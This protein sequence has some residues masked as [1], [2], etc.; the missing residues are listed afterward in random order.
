MHPRRVVFSQTPG[1]A[2]PGQDDVDIYT[3]VPGCKRLAIPKKTTDRLQP[4]DVF[5]SL[6]MKSIIL[7]A[8][9]RVILD[10]LPITKRTRDNIIRLVSLM[11]NQMSAKFFNGLIR[12]A[13]FASGYVDKHPGVFKTVD[14]VCFDK[15]TV[16]CQT[17]NCDQSPFIRCS[18][19]DKSLC[20]NHFFVEYDCM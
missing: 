11:H 2:W 10:Q 13:C 16:S 3:K 18:W 14:D 9:D 19:Y 1:L 20:F 12:C 7:R 5:Y 15:H 4:L 6:Q 8:H 17:T